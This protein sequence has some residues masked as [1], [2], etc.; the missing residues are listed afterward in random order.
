MRDCKFLLTFILVLFS[1]EVFADEEQALPEGVMAARGQGTVTP[2]EFDARVSRIPSQ[3]RNS[4]LR[5]ATKVRTI[6]ANLLLTSQL[7]AEARKNE[8]GQGDDQL[9]LRMEMAAETEFANAWLDH[10]TYTANDADYTAMA[11]EYYLLNQENFNSDPSVDVTH[12]LISTRERTVEEA[13]LLAQSYLDNTLSEPSA[14]DDLVALYSEDPSVGSNQGRF[15]GVKNGV[16]VKPFEQ[17]AFNLKNIGDFS[18]LVQTQFGFHIIRLDEIH[19]SQE[20]S[21]EEVRP[22]LE[23]T[24][25]KDH[26][27]RIREGY[28]REMTSMAT[29]ISDEEVEA[30]VHRYFDEDEIQL[31]SGS[32]NKE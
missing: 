25:A 24:I 27:E 29:R 19:P 9:K 12:L 3:D 31:Q 11:Q 8:F 16:M 1:H 26:R 14:F 32:S 13:K 2:Q 5:D 4:V 10:K 17:A 20:L 18:G 7:A 22:Q 15:T 6:L 30:M 28:L 21:F 23:V